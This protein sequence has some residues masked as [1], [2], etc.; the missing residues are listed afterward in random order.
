MPR[1]Q[2]DMPFDALDT[3]YVS[4][5]ILEKKLNRE[6]TTFTLPYAKGTVVNI[7]R[8]MNPQDGKP[9]TRVK[10]EFEGGQLIKIP[11]SLIEEVVFTDEQECQQASYVSRYGDNGPYME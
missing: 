8:E 9:Y 5:E 10:I 11:D 4:F 2:F 7:K 3:V 6:T 1:L